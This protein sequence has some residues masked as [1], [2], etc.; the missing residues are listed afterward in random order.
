MFGRTVLHTTL[1]PLPRSMRAVPGW[2][3][4][5]NEEIADLEREYELPRGSARPTF[6]R[7]IGIVQVEDDADMLAAARRP[8]KRRRTPR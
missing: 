3:A 2:I 6:K 5:N 8:R 7:L 4:M 1:D